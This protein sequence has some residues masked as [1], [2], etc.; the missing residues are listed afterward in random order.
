MIANAFGNRDNG[1][2]GIYQLPALVLV[3]PGDTIIWTNQD[4]APHTATVRDNSWDTG[5]ITRGMSK[6]ILVTEKFSPNYF[7][8][9][10][11]MMQAELQVVPNA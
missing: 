1:I 5:V 6:E 10:H 7:C 4:I 9:F 11:P 3:K 2:T 8:R